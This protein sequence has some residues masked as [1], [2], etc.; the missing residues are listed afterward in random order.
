D[1]VDAAHIHNLGDFDMD[2]L[3]TP[4]GALAGLKAARARGLI[5]FLAVSGHL[6][7]ARF[8]PLLDSGE[9]DL[10]MVALNFADRHNYDFEGHVLA[11]A[12][13]HKTAVVAMKVL[14]GAHKWQYDGKTPGTLADHHE[15]AIRY[16]LGLPGVCC[17]VIGFSNEEEVR[18]AIEV[19]RHF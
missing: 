16:S 13:K 4:E 19:A 11:V 9:I 12:K 2:K 15:Q 14:G 3:L 18:K 7:P 6:R 17:A 5:R 10:T 1:H 8:T